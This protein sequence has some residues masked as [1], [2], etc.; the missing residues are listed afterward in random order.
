M[1]CKNDKKSKKNNYKI[2]WGRVI[3]TEII[4]ISFTVFLWLNGAYKKMND[5]LK[6]DMRWSKD[7]LYDIC[8]NQLERCLP[9][10]S[11]EPADFIGIAFKWDRTKEGHEYWKKLHKKWQ[12]FCKI[13]NLKKLKEEED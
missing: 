3:Q 13:A 10:R 12:K 7:P 8:M 6:I 5:Q 11:G 9:N 1:T 4:L 2:D